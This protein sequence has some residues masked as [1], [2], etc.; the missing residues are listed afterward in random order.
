LAVGCFA[1]AE[2]TDDKTG[3]LPFATVFL[4]FLI[5]RFDLIWPLAMWASVVELSS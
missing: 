1:N 3:P 2:V 5:S 4:G